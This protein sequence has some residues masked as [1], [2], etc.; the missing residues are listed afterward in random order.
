[1]EENATFPFLFEFYKK[2]LIDITL[3]DDT[4]GW[5]VLFL[6]DLDHLR[7]GISVVLLLR[8]AALVLLADKTRK[9]CK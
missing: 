9:N 8:S 6:L 2:E 5:K 7:F 3:D 4:R 1:M